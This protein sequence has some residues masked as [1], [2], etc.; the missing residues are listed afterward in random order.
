MVAVG[1]AAGVGVGGGARE[2]A[3]NAVTPEGADEVALAVVGVVV[4]ASAVGVAVGVG[5]GGDAVAAAG[6][7][8]L[9][10]A[11]ELPERSTVEP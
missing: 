4:D 5:A 10:D 2:D 8:L 3:G 1:L 6:V 11:A 7:G 9:G